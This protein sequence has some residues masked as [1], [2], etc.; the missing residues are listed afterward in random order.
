MTT[1]TSCWRCWT[2][3]ALAWYGIPR[4]ALELPVSQSERAYTVVRLYV[5][6]H[7]YVRVNDKNKSPPSPLSVTYLSPHVTRAL[8]PFDRSGEPVRVEAAEYVTF[9]NAEGIGAFL[10]A[11]FDE[12]SS[13]LSFTMDYLAGSPLHVDPQLTLYM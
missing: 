3:R 10:D 8:P 2:D 12:L 11:D 9:H 7:L 4:G 5:C 1:T 6:M 13:I